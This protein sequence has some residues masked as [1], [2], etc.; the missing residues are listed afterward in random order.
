[1]GSR[2]ESQELVVE[3]VRKVG[4]KKEEK[5]ER[6]QDVEPIDTYE[7]LFEK[8][9][10]LHLTKRKDLNSQMTLRRKSFGEL[11]EKEEKRMPKY[12]RTIMSNGH[13]EILKKMKD[14][15]LDMKKLHEDVV[16]KKLAAYQ[17]DLKYKE[18]RKNYKQ[19]KH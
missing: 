5:E 15:N 10:I 19:K 14:M 2:K 12:V 13:K 18:W 3:E 4:K 17:E 11:L 1:M 6:K 9:R 8:K 16:L 7:D